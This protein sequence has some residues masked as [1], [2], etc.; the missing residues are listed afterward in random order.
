MSTERSIVDAETPPQ[1]ANN[2][3]CLRLFF[4]H[5]R[6]Q[7]HELYRSAEYTGI[8]R[9]AGSALYD[10]LY[11]FPW[12]TARQGVVVLSGPINPEVD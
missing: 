11:V 8:T 3:I 5:R 7:G 2:D 9:I 6:G 12:T 1:K 4:C 10:L